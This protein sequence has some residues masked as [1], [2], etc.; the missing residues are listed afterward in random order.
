M[1]EGQ[2]ATR[3]TRIEGA[4]ENVVF[5]GTYVFQDVTAPSVG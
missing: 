3:M 2:H 4:K 5:L 1:S